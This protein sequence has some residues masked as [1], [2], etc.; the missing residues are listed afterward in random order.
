MSISFTSL[1][2]SFAKKSA[3]VSFGDMYSNKISTFI[4]YTILGILFM[5]YFKRKA[6]MINYITE[7]LCILVLPTIIIYVGLFIYNILKIPVDLYN[8]V[9]TSE[10]AKKYCMN[11]AILLQ[12]G[13]NTQDINI[14]IWRNDAKKFIISIFGENSYELLIFSKLYHDNIVNQKFLNYQTMQLAMKM[15]T[16]GSIQD[17]RKSLIKNHNYQDNIE[18]EMIVLQWILEKFLPYTIPF[19]Q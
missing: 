10:D 7:T 1:Y 3:K 16:N 17:P 12:K 6:D 18:F 8:L 4:I 19:K 2:L 14:D 11:I 15:P 9:K 5:F 13:N